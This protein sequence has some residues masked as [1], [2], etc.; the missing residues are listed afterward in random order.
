VAAA[1]YLKS[2]GFVNQAEVARVLD[3]ATN[4][5]SLFVQYNDAKRSRNASVSGGAHAYVGAGA[6]AGMGLPSRDDVLA[7]MM[8]CGLRR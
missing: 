8:Q 3:I 1:T 5:N 7:Y 6:G 2:I 4:P